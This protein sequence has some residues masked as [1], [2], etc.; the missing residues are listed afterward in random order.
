VKTERCDQC[1]E[2]H[3]E[4]W[5]CNGCGK[6]FCYLCGSSNRV[7]LCANCD[8]EAWEAEQES[9]WEAT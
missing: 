8:Q 1:K 4:T 3:E 6:W 7:D 5:L 2:H 9:V